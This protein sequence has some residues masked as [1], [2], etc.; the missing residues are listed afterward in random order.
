MENIINIS[1]EIQNKF[2]RQT[3][4]IM[5][6]KHHKLMPSFYNKSEKKKKTETLLEIYFEYSCKYFK[7]TKS[8]NFIGT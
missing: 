1:R 5:V 4:Q 7:I 6:K 3:T 8:H 2:D